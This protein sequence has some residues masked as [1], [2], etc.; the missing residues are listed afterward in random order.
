MP[1]EQF[2]ARIDRLRTEIKQGQRAPGVERLLLPGELEHER[3]ETRRREG[4][5]VHD[6]TP[7]VLRTFCETLGLD[8]P[9][10]R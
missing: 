10:A 8:S 9:L 4:I 2:G 1:L 3:R 5:P 7:N 6:D